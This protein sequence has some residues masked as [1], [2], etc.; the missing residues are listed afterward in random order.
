MSWLSKLFNYVPAEEREGISLGKEPCWEVSCAKDFPSF[1]RALSDLVPSDSILYIEGGSPHDEIKLYL[2]SRKAMQ[3][4]KVAMGTIWPR[5]K[6][7]HMLINLENLEGLA[8]LAERHA[9]IEIAV[10]LH[11]Y[12]DNKVLL[13]WYDAFFDPF[14]ISKEIPEDK[15]NNFCSQLGIKYKEVV[16]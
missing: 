9:E 13:Q 6:I 7:F 10:H 15:V 12:K 3:I 4:A 8:Q 14:Y 11:I 16:K 1:L 2:E 5:P